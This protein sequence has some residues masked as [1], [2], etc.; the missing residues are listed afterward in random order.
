MKPIQFCTELSLEPEKTA[1]ARRLA[2]EENRENANVFAGQLRST[3]AGSSEPIPS[4][5]MHQDMGARDQT[6][7]ALLYGKKWAP[8]RTLNVRFLNGSS[9]VQDKVKQFAST[10]QLFANIKF[11]FNGGAN[12]E[13]RISFN[14]GGSN[15]YLGTDALSIPQDRQTMN[16]GWFDANTSDQEFSRTTIH[17][18]GHALGCIHEHQNPTVSIPW[19]KPAVYKYYAD[20]QS[21]PWSTAQVDSNLFAKY[22]TDVTQYSQFDA[23]SI[24]CYAVPE[25]LTIGNYSIGWNNYLSPMDKTFINRAYPFPDPGP[26]TGYYRLTN[27]FLNENRSLDTYS[28][29]NNTPFM[30]QTGNY[31]GQ[32]WS[33]QAVAGASGYYRLSNYFLG[34]SRSLDTYSNGNNAPFMGTTGNY[35]GQFWKFIPLGGGYFRLINSFLGIGRSLD[36]YSDQNN[37]PFMG[38]TGNYSGQ[39]W[40]V[41]KIA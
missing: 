4:P 7:L 3:E 8:G 30:G 40:K 35:S 1:E 19:D 5:L 10:W 11:N 17:E 21:P 29:M 15:S 26:F 27:A 20:T 25:S 32:Y 23:A 6:R 12:S 22:G 36:T 18:F 13:I 24:M 31:S 39:F 2:I 16:F 9:F 37:A 14:P 34:N 33:I 28:N 38:E 41:T